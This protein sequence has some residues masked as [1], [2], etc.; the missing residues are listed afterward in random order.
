[1][2]KYNEI[3]EDIIDYQAALSKALLNYNYE[4]I[5]KYS[6]KI[7]ILIRKILND[8]KMTINK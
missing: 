7:A 5:E 2:Y 6:N 1:M 8:N 3:L 4:Q